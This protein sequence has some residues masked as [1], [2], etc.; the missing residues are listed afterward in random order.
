MAGPIA[1]KQPS[2]RL[3]RRG[4]RRLGVA[5]FLGSQPFSKGGGG[6]PRACPG[7]YDQVCPSAKNTLAT[8]PITAAIQLI[9]NIERPLPSSLITSGSGK[10]RYG[11]PDA[12]LI[13]CPLVSAVLPEDRGRP[14]YLFLSSH[15]PAGL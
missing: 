5:R 13:S 12:P 2:P 14:P 15:G 4:P 1:E 8:K 7:H 6:D 10:P 9:C 3:K 11:P